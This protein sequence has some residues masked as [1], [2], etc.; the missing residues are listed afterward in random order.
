[1]NPTL[2]V[3]AVARRASVSTKTV[4]YYEAIGLLPRATRGENGYRYYPGEA[5]NRMSFFRS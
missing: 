5:I 4:R 3:G 1:M 2:T